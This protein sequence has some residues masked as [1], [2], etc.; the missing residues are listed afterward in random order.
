VKK[1]NNKKNDKP[2]V[3]LFKQPPPAR[4]ERPSGLNADILP[5]HLQEFVRRPPFSS[6][7]L[8]S[9]GIRALSSILGDRRDLF[10]AYCING[11]FTVALSFLPFTLSS[12][13][14]AHGYYRVLVPAFRGQL[15][16]TYRVIHPSFVGLF[17]VRI[18]TIPDVFL[19]YSVYGAKPVIHHSYDD[20]PTDYYYPQGLGFTT[21]I[22]ECV[23]FPVLDFRYLCQQYRC[24]K[25][26]VSYTVTDA[27]RR[28]T[29][30]V[31]KIMIELPSIVI[32]K[33]TSAMPMCGTFTPAHDWLLL[34][35]GCGDCVSRVVRFH[36]PLLIVSPQV[37][38][39]FTPRALSHHSLPLI[40]WFLW[41]L[42]SQP[43]RQRGAEKSPLF[44]PVLFPLGVKIPFRPGLVAC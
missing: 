29:L 31:C 12:P 30:A 25:K 40:C 26:I 33:S 11:D 1:N 36:A 6:I 2:N 21:T 4:K 14:P 15:D 18:C 8:W 27:Q 5:S 20:L 34:A 43:P 28:Y 41:W 38:G 22:K 3:Q 37:P 19:D 44:R 35:P 23:P 10:L 32:V 24:V 42:C 17:P 13:C 39:D 7:G 16:E 9:N